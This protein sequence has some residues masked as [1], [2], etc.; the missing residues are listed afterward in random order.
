MAK[1]GILRV[2]LYNEP[3]KDPCMDEARWIDDMRIR[4]QAFQDAYSD[5]R[6]AT[7]DSIKPIILGAPTSMA[8]N[9]SYAYVLC[10]VM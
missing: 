7:G 8:W 6:D 3:D 2:E 10:F 1:N 4:S 9:E 5:H